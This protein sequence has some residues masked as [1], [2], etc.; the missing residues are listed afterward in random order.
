[1]LYVAQ[2]DGVHVYSSKGQA[3]KTFATST[4]ANDVVM[5]DKG[6]AFVLY[7]QG[8]LNHVVRYKL[9]KNKPSATYQPSQPNVGGAIF[10]SHAG[11]L[12]YAYFFFVG[13]QITSAYDVWDPGVTG[14]PS[15]TFT[16]VNS[17][18]S[19]ELTVGVA[20]NG[21]L[22]VPYYDAGSQTQRY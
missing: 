3:V 17:P 18:S 16:H 21:T 20:Q 4:G 19:I 1:M 10:A 15:R 14:A 11:E 6:D 22:Y 8:G 12:V 13:S 9:G 2:G 5:D 7:N